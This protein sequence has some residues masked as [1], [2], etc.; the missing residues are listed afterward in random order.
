MC[1]MCMVCWR[2]LAAAALLLVTSA[3][4]DRA[5]HR[6]NLEMIIRHPSSY[7]QW[8]INQPGHMPS[9]YVCPAA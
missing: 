6:L 4:I 7:H 3:A 5:G 9:A 8:A 1:I 2:E